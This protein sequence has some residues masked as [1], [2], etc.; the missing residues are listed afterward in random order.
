MEDTGHP[1]IIVTV[2]AYES[3]QAHDADRYVL[4][5]NGGSREITGSYQAVLAGAVNKLLKGF[6]IKIVDFD[7]RYR[8]D[9]FAMIFLG[10]TTRS[11][12]TLDDLRQTLLRA[13]NRLG[14]SIRVQREDLFRFMHRV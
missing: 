13:G 2:L 5:V 12:C 10:D 11:T 9:C 7:Q 14:A 3:V 8:D 6:N 1:N 4:E